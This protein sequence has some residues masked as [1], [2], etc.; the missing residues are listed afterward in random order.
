[1]DSGRALVQRIGATD[2]KKLGVEGTA[3]AIQSVKQTLKSVE[4]AKKRVESLERNTR[5]AVEFLGQG[6]Q[7]VNQATEKDF[8]FAKSL[9]KLPTFSAPEIGEAF[10]GQVSIDRF[11]QAVYWAELAQKYMPPGLLPRPA[12][13]P[14]RLRASGATIE[15]PK[16]EEFP[17]FLLEQGTI[18]F[19]IGGATPVRGAYMATVRGLTSTPALFGRPAVITAGR[20]AAGSTIASIDVDAVI[21]HVTSR[22]V[23]S[24]SARLR[25]VKLPTFDLPGVPFRVV[26]GSGASELAFTM[27]GSELKGRWAIRSNQVSWLADTAGR[28]P[29]TLERLVWRVI[30]G[31]NDL[32]VVA[33]LGG[34]VASPRLSVSSN[35]DQAIAKQLKAVMGEEI[36]RAERMV[37]AKVDSVVAAEVEPVKRRVTA[38]QA[39]ANKR[40]Q[41]ERQQLEQVEADLN[42]QLKR[43]TGGLAPGIRLPEIK[44]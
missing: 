29:N 5:S 17:R 10:F 7:L 41:V 40:I 24:V 13:G 43:L 21:N 20:R 19:T 3:Q 34:S 44:L 39:E 6:V 35:L 14:Q 27:R 22:T 15:F 38:V 1:M 8:A 36:A 33:E 25:G 26:P 42:A 16:M 28:S 4:T 18:D 11:K 30:S 23:D 32:N 31:L 12:P 9:L 2:P 37:R